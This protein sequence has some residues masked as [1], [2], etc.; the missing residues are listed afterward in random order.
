MYTLLNENLYSSTRA[1]KS[2]IKSTWDTDFNYEPRVLE[3]ESYDG[4]NE[5]FKVEIQ[6]K[7]VC[8]VIV[9]SADSPISKDSLKVESRS[10]LIFIVRDF[11]TDEIYCK[12]PFYN[13]LTTYA[14]SIPNFVELGPGEL[15]DYMN[16]K[17]KEEIE[18]KYELYSNDLILLG[19]F[20][21]SARQLIGLDLEGS[22]LDK[23][24]NYKIDKRYVLMAY[25]MDSTFSNNKYIDQCMEPNSRFFGLLGFAIEC[26][27]FRKYR[28]L[29]GGVYSD[30]TQ[31]ESSILDLV[32]DVNNMF[33]LIMDTIEENTDNGMIFDINFSSY[34]PI[35]CDYSNQ[36]FEW[37]RKFGFTSFEHV[38][39]S[40]LQGSSVDY[41]D[42]GE[43]RRIIKVT[44]PYP[45]DD[46]PC[47][48]E[49]FYIGSEFTYSS[50]DSSTRNYSFLDH[51]LVTT[52]KF[53]TGKDDTFAI[54]EDFE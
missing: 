53:Y 41:M 5:R 4:S 28:Q 17:T 9:P 51:K 1:D 40:G 37:A 14:K 13:G 36:S 44:G 24:G 29:M 3:G 25:I 7:S 2:Q 16:L 20:F 54:L 49:S 31:P 19:K 27:D 39:S 45:L 10:Q 43:Y 48:V 52:T 50:W 8:S 12:I 18:R 22:L 23:D 15:I 38:Y 42:G 11:E 21:R 32:R 33:T 35:I 26:F 46:D 30:G 34:I 6:C 47:N